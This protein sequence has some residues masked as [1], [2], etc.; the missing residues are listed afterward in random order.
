MSASE[1]QRPVRRGVQ[2]CTSASRN[3]PSVDG[4]RVGASASNARSGLS[5]VVESALMPNPVSNAASRRPVFR[6]VQPWG[7]R[8]ATESTL[9]SE[10]NTAT[11][12]FDAIEQLACR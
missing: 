10:H 3:R 7:R 8:V 9:I 11:E 1:D 6:V 12:A 4:V 2:K 5:I